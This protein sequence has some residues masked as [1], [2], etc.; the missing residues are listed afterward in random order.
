MLFIWLVVGLPV[1]L[2]VVAA[3]A[4]VF[5]FPRVDVAGTFACLGVAWSLVTHRHRAEY[6]AG[7]A[8]RR[9]SL[10]ELRVASRRT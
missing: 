8:E 7:R 1:T 6:F 4:A 10:D 2:F 5:D 9:A 3:L